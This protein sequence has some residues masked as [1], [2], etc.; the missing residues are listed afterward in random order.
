MKSYIAQAALIV[1]VLGVSVPAVAVDKDC[2]KLKA[3]VEQQLKEKGDSESYVRIY[4]ADDKV[5][6][7]DMGL[8]N[9][10]T[11]KVVLI[12]VEPS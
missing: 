10:G 4:E 3:E 2:K 6:G 1:A 12:E 8:C 11:R 5:K 7:K 9:Q